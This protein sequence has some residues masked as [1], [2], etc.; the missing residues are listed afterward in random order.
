MLGKEIATLVNE[1][2]PAG[3]KKLRGTIFWTLSKTYFLYLSIEV[4]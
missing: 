4:N 2:K 1:E 3:S